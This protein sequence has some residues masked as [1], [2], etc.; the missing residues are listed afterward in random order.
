MDGFQ[1]ESAE[2]SVEQVEHIIREAIKATL[3][4][5]TYNPK[6]VNE[7]TN[8]IVTSCLKSLQ[9]LGITDK[10]EYNE[11]IVVLTCRL[12]KSFKYIITCMIMQKN[13]AGINTTTSMF[14]DASKDGK[15]FV[16]LASSASIA[17]IEAIHCTQEFAKYLGRTELCSAW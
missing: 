14:W 5:S 4:D 10:H 7:W 3:H 11:R 16:Y 17:L 12:G 9:E 1:D 8:L 15:P 13:G 2:F 6:K